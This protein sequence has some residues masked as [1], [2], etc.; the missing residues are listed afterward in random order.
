MEG[1]PRLYMIGIPAKRCIVDRI[2]DFATTLNHVI[3]AIFFYNLCRAG[4]LALWMYIHV[5]LE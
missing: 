1:V 3:I 5:D 2:P 4:S